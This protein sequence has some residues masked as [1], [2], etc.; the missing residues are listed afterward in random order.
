MHRVLKLG[1]EIVGVSVDVVLEKLTKGCPQIGGVGTI[2]VYEIEY[3]CGDS[4]VDPLNNGEIIF[5][6][7]RIV[8]LR[9]S[10]VSDVRAEAASPEVDVEEVT[11][12]VVVV[13]SE[14]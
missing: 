9:A 8:R 7:L 4:H 3:F 2:T 10:V 6:P 5:D 12:M 1:V 11:A 13:S 14:V